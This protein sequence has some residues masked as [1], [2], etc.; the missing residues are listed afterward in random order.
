MS[1]VLPSASLSAARNDAGMDTRPLA[2][3]LFVWVPR[4]WV[5]RLGAPASL[6]YDCLVP[7]LAFARGWVEQ[8]LRP[9]ICQA[10]MG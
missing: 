3:S 6:F 4:N 8:P 2:S 7:R 5:I 9:P 1:V 10:P